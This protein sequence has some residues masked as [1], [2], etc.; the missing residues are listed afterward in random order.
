MATTGSATGTASVK[1][2]DEGPYAESDGAP[3]LTSARVTYAYTGDIEAEGT[4]RSAMFYSDEATATYIGYER[5]VGTLA[6]RSGSFVLRTTGTYADG[7]ALSA[8]SVVPGSGTGELA[9]LRG[10]GG[11]V[12]GSGSMD[13]SY[14]LTYH[15]A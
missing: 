4:S 8:T 11:V 6:G 14:Q 10:E 7:V 15:L 12:A 3:K 13:V 9:G 1:S 2:W 5:V